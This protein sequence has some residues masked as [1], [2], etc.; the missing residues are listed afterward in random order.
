[1]ARRPNA[2]ETLSEHYK[3]RGQDELKRQG[4]N[5]LEGNAALRTQ[6]SLRRWWLVALLAGTGALVLG[7]AF[8]GWLFLMAKA[9][10]QQ[11]AEVKQQAI[12][13]YLPDE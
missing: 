11:F 7:I 13:A 12:R 10:G 2:A 1:M 9:T 3:S 5:H 6:Q 4:R 8:V